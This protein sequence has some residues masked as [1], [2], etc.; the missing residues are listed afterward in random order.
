[1]FLKKCHGECELF[2]GSIEKYYSNVLCSFILLEKAFFLKGAAV[3]FS[4]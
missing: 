1:M 2:E 4:F 3:Y